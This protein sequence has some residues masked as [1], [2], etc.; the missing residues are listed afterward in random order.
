MALHGFT[1]TPVDTALLAEGSQSWNWVAPALP[2]HGMSPDGDEPW[3]LPDLFAYLNSLWA[4]IEDSQPRVLLGYS[5]GGRLALHY[6]GAFP[7]KLVGL[8]LVGASP[9]LRDAQDRAARRQ[10]D[11][12]LAQRVEKMGT[13]AFL[14]E[15]NELPL[16]AT[17]R[18]NIDPNYY[19]CMLRARRQHQAQGLAASLRN[20]GTGAL[21]SAWEQLSK[22]DLPV[23][24][25]TGEADP[26]FTQIA[27]Q[28]MEFL[29]RVTHEILPVVGHAAHLEAGQFFLK[30]L[31]KWM[32]HEVG[33]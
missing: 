26:K 21:P 11:E 10:Y 23:L 16:I 15:W 33:I 14:K 9:G 25:V 4:F 27:N 2:G 12:G 22:L 30:K 8:V 24:L 3:A 31:T 7:E 32:R 17:Q 1:G 6:A 5:M 20:H 13:S 29:P 28:M 19:N 18:T